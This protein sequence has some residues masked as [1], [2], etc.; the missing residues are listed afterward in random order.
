[1]ISSI[2]PHLFPL[3]LPFFAVGSP[4][5]KQHTG[6]TFQ[7]TVHVWEV[8][9]LSGFMSQGQQLHHTNSDFSPQATSFNYSGGVHSSFLGPLGY[10]RRL[11]MTGSRMGWPRSSLASLDLAWPLLLF[12]YNRQDQM[13]CASLHCTLPV[14]K[15]LPI[16]CTSVRVSDTVFGSVLL[17]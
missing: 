5:R 9:H 14:C 10:M 6:T 15:V 4:L 13:H 7:F 2:R 11:S 16:E 12:N 3:I 17:A 8:F 1:M